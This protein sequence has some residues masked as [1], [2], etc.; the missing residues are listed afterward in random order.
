VPHEQEGRLSWHE[1]AARVAYALTAAGNERGAQES[2][3]MVQEVS[4]LHG[5]T[6]ATD[7]HEPSTSLAAARLQ[8]MLERRL[9]GEPVQYVLGSW[10]FRTLELLVDRRVLIPRPETEQV[11][12]VALHV[13]D[14]VREQLHGGGEVSAVRVADL[15]TGSGAIGLAIAA[16]RA[17]TEVW[18]T[19]AAADALD[20]ARANLAGLGRAGARVSV[21]EGSWFAALDPALRGTLDLVISNPPY[22]S[23]AEYD[24]LEPAVRDYEPRD[25]LVPGQTGLE[26]IEQILH[27]APAWLTPVGAVVLEIGE[28]QGPSATALALD[29]GFL[30]V[31]VF[32]DLT[33]RDRTLRAR[34]R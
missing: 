15:G 32:P 24:Q 33:G 3:W 4:G 10:A 13:L 28:T 18:L 21:A 5:A 25:A 31:Q 22:V 6:W 26:A 16:E 17:W 8:Q 19:D 14:A 34:L 1:L 2:Q 27:E 11:V 30:D 9:T 29:A 7:A 20:V 12:E 23:H